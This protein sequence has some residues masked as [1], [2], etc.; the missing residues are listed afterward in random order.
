MIPSTA[1]VGSSSLELVLPVSYDYIEIKHM[2][3][4]LK[5]MVGAVAL[6]ML[7]ATPAMAQNRTATVN[8]AKVFDN[9]WKKDQ[10]QAALDQRRSEFEKEGKGMMDDYNKGRD[11]YN[12]LLDSANDQSVTPE[13]RE[14]RKAAAEDKLRELKTTE[15]TI[16]TFKSTMD[17]QLSSQTKRMRD[18]ILQDIRTAVTA[19][20]KASGF[21][22]VIDSSAESI[23]GFPVLLYSN[24]DNDMTESI[25]SQLNAGAPAAADGSKTTP[26]SDEKK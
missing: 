23:N 10:A 11:E 19:K 6:A 9:Y 1:A 24:G 21:T 18:A 5:V 8:M 16:R 25:L 2:K 12:K 17:D 7:L 22:M 26:K 15:N 4:M 13:A 3:T 14:K 20:A